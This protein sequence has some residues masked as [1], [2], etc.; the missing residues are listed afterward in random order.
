[1]PQ[2]VGL[3]PNEAIYQISVLGLQVQIIG[4]GRVVAQSIPMGSTIRPGQ[5]V[6]LHLGNNHRQ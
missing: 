3:A 4:Y 1:M 2:L 6:V 5:K